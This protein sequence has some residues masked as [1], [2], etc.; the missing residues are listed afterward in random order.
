MGVIMKK[1]FSIIELLIVIAIIA[2][3]LPVV[4]SLFFATLQS[5]TKVLILQEVKRNGDF[6]LDVIEDLVRTRAYAI[7]SDEELTTEVCSTKTSTLTPT[8]S[9]TV[10]F[11][12]SSGSSF[13][14]APQSQKIA[15]YSAVINPNPY[16][17]T[18]DKVVVSNFTISCNRTAVLS[19]PIV[20]ISFSVAQPAT[21]VRHE[22]QATLNYQTKIKLRSY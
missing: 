12:D 3:T 10:F 11:S 6:A 21:D 22:Q 15:S 9:G 8:S 17:L 1:G 2:F 7:Y 5:Q 19:P 14:F 20:S 4:F 16:Y 18:S 13:Y